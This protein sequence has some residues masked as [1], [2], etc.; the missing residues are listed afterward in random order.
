VTDIAGAARNTEASRIVPKCTQGILGAICATWWSGSATG[1]MMTPY[2]VDA[3]R[4]VP[5]TKQFRWL[6]SCDSLGHGCLHDDGRGHAPGR[7][8]HWKLDLDQTARARR[9]QRS[10][11]VSG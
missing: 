7:R 9:P 10:V 3:E 6:A 1:D 4:R 8:I 5:M 11:R 2:A